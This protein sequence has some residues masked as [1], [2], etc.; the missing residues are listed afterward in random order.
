MSGKPF[1]YE[2]YPE[3]PG[4]RIWDVHD[5]SKF[6]SDYPEWEYVYSMD[7]IINDVISKEL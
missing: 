6:R 2:F 4:D 1:K 3:R 5:V 7:D